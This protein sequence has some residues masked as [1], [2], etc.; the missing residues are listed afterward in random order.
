MMAI[1][2]PR[3]FSEMY[4]AEA[5]PWLGSMKHIWNMLSLPS[6]VAVEEA[7]GVRAKMRSA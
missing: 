5:E 1:L 6:V 4:R 2:L 3:P 7:E